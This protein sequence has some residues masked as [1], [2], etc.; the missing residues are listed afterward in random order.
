MLTTPHESMPRRPAKVTFLDIDGTLLPAGTS[1]VPDRT[2]RAVADV[3][4]RGIKVVLATGR[5]VHNVLPVAEQFGMG[6]GC[7][8]IASNGA[9]TGVVTGNRRHPYELL[10]QRTFDPRGAFS[11]A[12][13]A[14][15]EV[16]MAV[17]VPGVGWR[18]N[19][20]FAPG[21]LSG[22]QEL[23]PPKQLWSDGEITRA[24]IRAPGVAGLVPDLVGAGYTAYAAGLDHVDITRRNVS[25]WTEADRL[26]RRWR[27]DR[28][29]T[30]AAGDGENDLPLIRQAGWSC[31]MWHAPRHV[32][33][34]ANYVAGP[35][36][37]EGVVP[38]LDSLVLSN[39]VARPLPVRAG[40]G[41][42]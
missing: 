39:R 8:F 5:P 26:R 20:R 25:K 33:E 32:L 36:S 17:E 38:W 10:D 21:Q 29:D 35:V 7:F 22:E 19:A 4:A 24:I 27:I 3:M 40:T 13:A 14:H 41:A 11:V 15:R 12:M 9:V 34:A 2:R 28:F 1:T 37:E 31:A 6:Q 23:V 30:A 18:V 42:S 16:R